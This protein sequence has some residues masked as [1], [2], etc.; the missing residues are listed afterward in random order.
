M[1]SGTP[2]CREWKS[3]TGVKNCLKSLRGRGG[4][5]GVKRGSAYFFGGCDDF[6]PT[7]L[8]I[9]CG[10]LP[11][12]VARNCRARLDFNREKVGRIWPSYESLARFVGAV[13]RSRK[14]AQKSDMARLPFS[15]EGRWQLLQVFP[16]EIVRFSFFCF[17]A[18]SAWVAPAVQKLIA[19]AEL[20]RD[21]CISV[22]T[23]ARLP[24]KQKG[25][26]RLKSAITSCLKRKQKWRIS[27][28]YREVR[29]FGDTPPNGFR[30]FWSGNDDLSATSDI[31][32]PSAFR[33]TWR[34]LLDLSVLGGPW[35]ISPFY[36]CV[37]DASCEKSAPGNKQTRNCPNDAERTVV[38]NIHMIQEY[39]LLG[40]RYPKYTKNFRVRNNK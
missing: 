40:G 31:S 21:P 8:F 15:G 14:N 11:P 23:Y 32:P 30:V 10:Q 22:I 34:L 26:A 38:R 1:R 19:R 24:K 33:V 37:R 3:L 16:P 13:S 9:C 28:G 17:C 25:G 7:K 2:T 4:R 20:L 6:M 27:P 36:R 18:C 5:H 12:T 39:S 35:L 29:A